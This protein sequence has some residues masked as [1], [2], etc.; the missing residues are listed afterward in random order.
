MVAFVYDCVTHNAILA[1][2]AMTAVS[3]AVGRATRHWG[4]RPT[5][6]IHLPRRRPPVPL[7]AD[8]HVPIRHVAPG[9]W[10]RK[11]RGW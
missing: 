9:T 7:I 5:F 8:R 4:I 2:V 1:I 3:A 6:R 11:P 10:G